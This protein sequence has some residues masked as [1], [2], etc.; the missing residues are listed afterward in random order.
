MMAIVQCPKGHFYDD[1]KYFQCPHCGVSLVTESRDGSNFALEDETVF[2]SDLEPEEDDA[3]V[4]F[5][6]N[7]S[8]NEYVTGWLVCIDGPA[9]GEDYRL[10]YGFNRIGRSYKMDVCIEEDLQVTRDNHCSIVYEVRENEFYIMPSTGTVTYLNNEIV[11]ESKKIVTGDRIRIGK[12][13]LEFVAF[14]RGEK[15]WDEKLV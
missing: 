5:W 15:K 9:K 8:E 4:A 14:C 13:L 7:G 12:S 1:D 2:L 10:H 3:T 6:G 11:M